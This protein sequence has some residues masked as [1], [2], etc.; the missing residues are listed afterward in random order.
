MGASKWVSA[1]RFDARQEKNASAMCID[2]LRQQGYSIVATSPHDKQCTPDS[3]P[4]DKPLAVFFGNEKEGLS[5]YVMQEADYHMS[6]PM[7]GFTESL[8]ISVSAAMIMKTLYERIIKEVSGWQLSDEEKNE[9]RLQWLS[10]SLRKSDYII[11]DY[12]K[13]KENR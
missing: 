8:N 10:K 7:Y 11:A 4:L 3:I 6:V 2:E 5:D 13:E 12:Y 9:L 1:I